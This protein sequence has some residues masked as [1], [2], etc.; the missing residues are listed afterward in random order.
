MSAVT[1][2]DEKRNFRTYTMAS[3]KEVGCTRDLFSRIRY[4]R[5]MVPS[6]SPRPPHSRL[7]VRVCLGLEVERL[8]THHSSQLRPGAK[9]GSVASSGVSSIASARGL[10]RQAT[11]LP[12]LKPPHEPIQ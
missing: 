7:S 2:I 11:G 5:T 6:S 10:Q 8:L 1:F 3:I 12:V 4:A 9:T